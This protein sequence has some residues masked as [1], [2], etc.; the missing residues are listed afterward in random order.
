[1]IILK[2]IVLFKEKINNSYNISYYYKYSIYKI[3]INI[4]KM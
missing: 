4:F 3:I 1:M 2:F